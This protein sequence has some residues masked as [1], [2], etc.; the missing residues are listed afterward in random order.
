M[1][2]LTVTGEFDY[3][4]GEIIFLTATVESPGED[5]SGTLYPYD[6]ITGHDPET[7]GN[8]IAWFFGDAG[9]GLVYGEDPRTPPIIT[10]YKPVRWRVL[11][12]TDE[13]LK[14]MLAP[15]DTVVYE[16]Q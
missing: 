11:R 10:G 3:R 5:S 14:V 7:E 9:S 16:R 1:Q 6:D 13:I 12:L 2:I 8:T 4:K 15:G